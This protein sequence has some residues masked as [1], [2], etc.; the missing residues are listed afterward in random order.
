MSKNYSKVKKYYKT[1]AWDVVKVRNA[2][3]MGWITEE[4]FEEITNISYLPVEEPSEEQPEEL[5]ENNEVTEN[6]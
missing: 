4:E 6:E 5:T 3:V 2:V 1:G